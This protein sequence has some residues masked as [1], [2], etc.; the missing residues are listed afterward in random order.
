[1]KW[2]KGSYI[3]FVVALGL[4]STN[5][6]ADEHEHGHD[7]HG[8]SGE[9]CVGFGPQTPRDIDSHK[10]NNKG[11]F[12]VAPDYKEMNLCNIHF[13][14]N[15]EH[16]AAAF[17]IYAGDGDGHG[18]NSGYQC[19]MSK[20]LSKAELA[21]TKNPICK[22]DHG[23]IK[24]GDTIEVHWVHSTCDV[25]P[26]KSLGSCLSE[27]CANPEL[28]VETQVFTLVNDPNALDFN[29]LDY[30]GNM[31]H[32]LHQAKAIPA[33]TGEPVEFLG[34]TTGP[35]YT[36]QTCSPYQVTW[37]VRPQCAKIDINTVGKWCEG[38][39]FEEDHAHGVRKL[40]TNPDLL[41]KIK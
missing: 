5:A 2:V 19:N 33:N 27:A 23:E 20:K 25:K 17:S 13:H 35:S 38:N 36:E 24:P 39:E 12:R 11:N 15:A 30:D 22:S 18:Y 40:V 6:I 29:D 34:S 32:G 3:C 16:K 9:A 4:F 41:S 37:S 28:R 8:A 14:K 21:P 31:V 7:G 10:G 1:M 26:G